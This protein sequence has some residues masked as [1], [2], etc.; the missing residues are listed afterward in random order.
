MEIH[1]PIDPPIPLGRDPLRELPK[2]PLTALPD[3]IR[4]AAEEVSRFD[5]VPIESPATIAISML[6]TA[7]GKNAII[8]EK[9]GL[10]HFP[11]LFFALIAKSGER[12]S[13][14]FKRMQWPFTRYLEENLPRYTLEEREAESWNK[15]IGARIR[16]LEKEA[17]KVDN[18]IS[19]RDI[20][21]KMAELKADMMP[22]PMDPRRF[23]SDATEQVLFK[24]MEEHGGQYSVQS[25]EGRPIFDAILG[26]YSGSDRT[27][28]GIYLAGISGD[29]ITRDRIGSADAGGQESGVILKPCLNVCVMIQP[30]KYLQF[31]KHPNL[32]QSGLIARICPVWLPS[33]VGIRLESINEP[34]LNAKAMHPYNHL[35]Y[36]LLET[37][38][39]EPHRV[40]LSPDAKELRR[41]YHN[42][43]ERMMRKDGE[44][45]DVPDIASKATSQAVKL[46]LVIHLASFPGFITHDESAISK[47]TMSRAIALGEYFLSQAVASQRYANEDAQ[48]EPARRIL[49]WMNKAGKGKAFKFSEILQLSP[50]PRPS[51]KQLIPVM[52]LLV[53]HRQVVALDMGGKHPDYKL[54]GGNEN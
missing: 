50:R 30:D 11:S 40:T 32:K 6:A 43:I 44:Y 37:L 21:S 5:K 49:E 8:E 23:T 38:R 14:P 36:G 19:R 4:Q 7:I 46:A 47:E 31:S 33:L 52:E 20:S 45:E 12:K 51:A 15:S 39:D 16:K 54:S 28:D 34:G 9:N 10:E 3:P 18:P 24:R 1:L 22:R 48:L 17:E 25:G 35:V 29:V 2:F 53:E 41:E 27:G 42:E 13:P 26:K